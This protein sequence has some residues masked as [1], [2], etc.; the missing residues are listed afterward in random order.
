MF[1]LQ[2]IHFLKGY[3]DDGKSY[4]HLGGGLSVLR[5]IFS[6]TLI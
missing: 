5:H 4:D 2:I 6:D 3:E 1:V